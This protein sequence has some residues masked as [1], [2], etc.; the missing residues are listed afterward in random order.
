MRAANI[1]L[2]I[3]GA[4]LLT[5][6]VFAV[7]TVV[8][9]PTPFQAAALPF[10]NAYIHPLFAQRWELFAPEPSTVSSKFWYRSRLRGENWGGWRDPADGLLRDYQQRRVF[11]KSKLLD[12]HENVGRLL[13]NEAVRIRDSLAGDLLSD[14]DLE[15]AIT[16]QLTRTPEYQLA[17]RYVGDLSRAEHAGQAVAAI[18][19]MYVSIQ[20]VPFSRRHDP[21]ARET[22]AS[23]AFPPA[24]LLP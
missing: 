6:H 9:P 24:E 14:V 23:L 4:A 13:N 10:V 3:C 16:S 1:F 17:V 18:Q 5:F 19:F 2:A 15:K 11:Y 8:G 21:A 7:A 20:P 22:F 12:V